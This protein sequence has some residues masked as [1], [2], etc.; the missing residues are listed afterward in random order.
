MSRHLAVFNIARL[1]APRGDPRV[2]SFFDGVARINAIAERSPGFVWQAHTGGMDPHM[3]RFDPTGRTI[4]QLS[5]WQ[6][7]QDLAH[8]VWNTLHRQYFARAGDWFEPS[9][10]RP[11]L[12][13]WWVAL[14]HIPDCAEG[15][16]RLDR[17][18]RA[19]PGK[20]VFG[21][22]AFRAEGLVPGRQTAAT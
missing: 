20:A 11:Y 19:G 4:P 10:D 16:A 13:F 9:R 1:I 15:L 6:S 3:L 22:E 18:C 8:F 17:L 21:W 14:G 2:Q 7:A 12:V 5:V